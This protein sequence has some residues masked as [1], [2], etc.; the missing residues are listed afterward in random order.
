M[1]GFLFKEKALT[2]RGEASTT[3][4]L[5]IHTCIIFVITF[6]GQ[7]VFLL[8]SHNNIYISRNT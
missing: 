4:S 1:F 5:R 6:F 2:V 7:Q 8:I 3:T